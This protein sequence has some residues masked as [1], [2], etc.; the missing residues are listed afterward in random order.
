MGVDEDIRFGKQIPPAHALLRGAGWVL[1][2]PC[3]V[4]ELR[5]CNDLNGL[6]TPEG[7]RLC[8][9]KLDTSLDLFLR[10]GHGKARSAPPCGSFPHTGIS[11]SGGEKSDTGRT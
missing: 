3:L 6:D 5:Q 7:H 1:P 8:L 4:R 2:R 9:D 10:T 11:P